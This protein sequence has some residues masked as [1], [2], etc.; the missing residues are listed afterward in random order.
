MDCLNRG[1]TPDVA[2][3]NAADNVW[4][5]NDLYQI[6][7][8]ITL[9]DNIPSH[10]PNKLWR[11][12]VVG[13]AGLLALGIVAAGCGPVETSGANADIP[14]AV[15]GAPSGFPVPGIEGTTPVFRTG[16]PRDM[17]IPQAEMTDPVGKPLNHRDL[18][19]KT[20]SV[21]G[22]L[23]PP[24]TVNVLVSGQEAWVPADE[25]GQPK[26]GYSAFK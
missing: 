8:G 19:E 9:T 11:R 17:S 23:N 15:G 14:A 22:I 5:N 12:L 6:K 24:G 3:W 18:N 13:G 20:G 26:P 7:T 10:N 25:A 1:I 4:N 21:D 16:N 2:A